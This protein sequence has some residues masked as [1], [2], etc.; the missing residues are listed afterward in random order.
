MARLPRV[1]PGAALCAAV[2][3]GKTR[4][5][6]NVLLLDAETAASEDSKEP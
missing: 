2:R 5:I 3:A 4:L 6:D 1:E